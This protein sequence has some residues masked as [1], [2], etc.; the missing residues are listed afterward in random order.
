MPGMRS[1][2]LDAVASRAPQCPPC[3]RA[4]WA[5]GVY[6]HSPGPGLEPR[7]REV[8]HPRGQARNAGLAGSPPVRLLSEAAK[9]RRSGR[10]AREGGIVPVRLCCRQR[11][12]ERTGVNQP[13]VTGTQ[14]E[15]ATSRILQSHPRG[16]T[17]VGQRAGLAGLQSPASMHPSSVRAHRHHVE[18]LQVAAGREGVGQGARQ[19]GAA[20]PARA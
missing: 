20:H 6:K 13:C 5:A 1:T 17:F 18:H 9:R 16:L 8:P 14:S 4:R 15:A 11:G 19:P 12:T 3:Q 10:A 2:C 7:A